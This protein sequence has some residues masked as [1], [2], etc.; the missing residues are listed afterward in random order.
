M[1]PAQA[2]LRGAHDDTL[3]Q[4]PDELKREFKHFQ[5]TGDGFQLMWPSDLS[6]EV[7]SCYVQVFQDS[8]AKRNVDR[9]P[10]VLLRVRLAMTTGFAGPGALGITGPAV[11]KAERLVEAVQA[12]RLQ[13][14][15][16]EQQL[17]LI[18]DANVHEQTIR[19]GY[20]VG[21]DGS[22]FVPVQVRDK[23]DETHDAQLAVPGRTADE[24]RAVVSPSL[25]TR[26]R[27]CFRRTVC[28]RVGKVVHAVRSVPKLVLAA[29][30][31]P[32]MA[33]CAVAVLVPVAFSTTRGEAPGDGSAWSEATAP[34]AHERPGP[35]TSRSLDERPTL[36]PMTAPSASSAP[37]EGQ[38][39]TSDTC[40][41]GG[42]AREQSAP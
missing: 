3:G 42:R 13:A 34:A 40:G 41:S 1:G 8:L 36:T 24:V 9:E 18:F 38:S 11:I 22:G 37:G 2:A 28:P 4:M 20:A 26:M 29:A 27:R 17:V 15:F 6:P 16:P 39:P 30:L 12:K 10:G 31:V 35:A 19:D 7:V 23:Y 32:A 25:L 33:A 5:E 14:E 21:V